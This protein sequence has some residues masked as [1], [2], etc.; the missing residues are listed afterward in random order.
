MRITGSSR[1][2]I[3]FFIHHLMCLLLN[4]CRKLFLPLYKDLTCN[5][6]LTFVTQARSQLHPR[7]N[8][9]AAV[10]TPPDGECQLYVIPLAL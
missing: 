10:P 5:S 2:S 9:P 3:L 1:F 4:S 8:P 6:N 7:L